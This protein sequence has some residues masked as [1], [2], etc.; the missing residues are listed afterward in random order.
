M[1]SETNKH[2]VFPTRLALHK[3]TRA[4]KRHYPFVLHNLCVQNLQRTIPRPFN[5]HN[6]IQNTF[7]L[8]AFIKKHSAA[9]PFAHRFREKELQVAARRIRQQALSRLRSLSYELCFVHY[10]T[11]IAGLLFAA[12][13]VP[14]SIVLLCFMCCVIT[15]TLSNVGSPFLQPK[16]PL[17]PFSFSSSQLF[18]TF[19]PCPDWL[20]V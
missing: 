15:A 20:C 14:L 10:S 4:L 6:R 2:S 5:M 17:L 16:H 12:H 13:S 11:S 8:I 1:H 3:Q 9:P 19:Q 7:L 18:N